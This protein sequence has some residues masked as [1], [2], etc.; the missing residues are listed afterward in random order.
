MF[1]QIIALAVTGLAS[2][3]F[4]SDPTTPQL[5]R[6]KSNSTSLAYEGFYLATYH[7]GAGL[8]DATL[9]SNLSNAIGGAF[10]N[11]TDNTTIS[12]Y[13]LDFNTSIPIGTNGPP[14]YYHANFLGLG[15]YSS[16]QLL[17]I[18]IAEAPVSGFTFDGEGRLAWQNA[19]TWAACEF[20]HTAYTLMTS[21]TNDSLDI[22]PSSG[23]FLST[24]ILHHCRVDVLRSS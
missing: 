16:L 5:L 8:A 14:L 17:T 18:N 7:Q 22:P 11:A 1:R 12:G 19:T 23:W 10:L 21:I 3:V 13:Y 20:V 4:A 24:R 15:A 6:A 2:L 9:V